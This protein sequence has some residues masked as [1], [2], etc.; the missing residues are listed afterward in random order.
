MSSSNF[1]CHLV[2]VGLLVGSANAAVV[3][4][5]DNT[6]PPDDGLTS[7]AEAIEGLQDGEAITFNI[8][9][10][11]PHYI[12][13]PVGGYSLIEKPDVTIDGYSQPGSSANTAGLR[14]PNNAVLKIV[15]DSRNGA[16]RVIDYPGFGTGESAVLP[17]YDAPN[18]KVR[19]LAFI[20][21]PGADSDADPSVYNIA[22]IKGSTNA[23]VQGCWFGLD[24]GAAPFA[25]NSNG[26]RPGIHG[27]RS[28][29]ASFKW[30]NTITSSGLLIGTDSDGVEDNGEFNLIV[31]QRLAIH[32]ETPDVT[33]SG[34]WLNYLPNGEIFHYLRQGTDLGADGTIEAIENGRA[35]NMRIGTNGDGV[36][37]AN[38]GNLFG[39]LNYT[40]FMEFWRSATGI[41]IAG[42][43]IGTDLA[44]RPLFKT[45]NPMSLLIVRSLSSVRIGSNCDGANDALEGNQIYGLHEKF[46][47]YHSSNN[48][49]AN[50]ARISLR[51]NDLSGNYGTIPLLLNGAL[52]PAIIYGAFVQNPAAGAPPSLSIS[53]PYSTLTGSVRAPVTGA[54][55]GPPVIDLYLAD[56]PTL[57]PS[58]VSFPNGYPQGRCLIACLEVDGPLDNDPSPHV[59]S[60]NVSSL[61]LTPQQWSQRVVA[62][63]NYLLNTGEVG[64]SLF[65]APVSPGF[66]P[67]PLL[68]GS[69]SQGVGEVN[70]NWSGGYYPF[71]I[72]ETDNLSG[73]WETTQITDDSFAIRPIT[74]TKR[75]FRVRENAKPVILPPL[76]Q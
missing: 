48:T 21:V 12:E 35:N 61:G 46:I 31:E 44:G 38:E 65:S 7:L 62:T 16:R 50:S 10:P 71:A 33:V 69:I 5:A 63:A 36:N 3:N 58:D 51:G 75:F 43:S 8:P 13:T 66:A 27:A 45:P 18:F 34:N 64:T 59:F 1:F 42:N 67:P 6:S 74:G 28:A 57:F 17:V 72:E 55:S 15:L 32:L 30:D 37:D 56:G 47:N 20:G 49:A 4:T 73:P 19:G 26:V 39:P 14:E 22:L 70:F 25:P 68:A 2:L 76:A 52:N 60:F 29:V 23:K 11:G 41:V 53:A 40:A 54:V 24:P 9:G